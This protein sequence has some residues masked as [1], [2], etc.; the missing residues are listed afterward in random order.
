LESKGLILISDTTVIVLVGNLTAANHQPWVRRWTPINSFAS[1]Q[2]FF[3]AV[4]KGK[5][6]PVIQNKSHLT[7]GHVQAFKTKQYDFKRQLL[8][9]SFMALSPEQPR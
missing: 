8:K 3:G 4:R 5:H 7:A 2:D 6:D 1:C 9:T